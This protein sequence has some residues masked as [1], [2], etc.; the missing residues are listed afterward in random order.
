MIYEHGRISSTNIRIA[1]GRTWGIWQRCY[2]YHNHRHKHSVSVLL[3]Q[4][5]ISQDLKKMDSCISSVNYVLGTIGTVISFNITATE[6]VGDK[7]DRWSERIS[8]GIRIDEETRVLKRSQKTQW[9]NFY[10][11]VWLLAKHV[12]SAKSRN[13]IDDVHATR[14]VIMD[15]QILYLLH[16]QVDCW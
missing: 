9:Y 5:K 6:Y 11:L 14:S 4:Q 3:Y 1:I 12:R 16:R 10:Q 2:H 13:I 7:N 15:E 8:I